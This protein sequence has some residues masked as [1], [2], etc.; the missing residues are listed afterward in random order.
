MAPEVEKNLSE[1]TLSSSHSDDDDP[2]S[3]SR[4]NT[5]VIKMSLSKESNPNSDSYTRKKRL[6]KETK[7]GIFFN[8]GLLALLNYLLLVYLPGGAVPSI[9]GMTLL[10]CIL[11]R[12]QLL[13]DLRRRR[14]DR[15]SLVFTLM[16]FMASFL[17]LCTYVRIGKK[18]GGVYE[19]PAR[20][21]GYD[22][23]N[24]N[25]ENQ[26]AL[27][28]DLEVEWG[29]SWGC[30]ESPN[31]KCR[32]YVSG[33]LC[34]VKESRKI[35][36]TDAYYDEV[37]EYQKEFVKEEKDAVKEEAEENDLEYVRSPSRYSRYASR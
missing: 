21:V 12:S 11:L 24:Y 26:S 7:L 10:S 29:G 16:I 3:S 23:T 5:S 2:D 22:V 14:F 32:A 20:I 19:G 25:N 1:L 15:I 13:E 28:T 31:Q 27:R 8:V 4:R 18:E 36:M 6:H 30:P 37:M 17:S 33:A 35:E 9:I 34:E